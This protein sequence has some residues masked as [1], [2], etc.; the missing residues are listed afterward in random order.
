MPKAF[1][2]VMLLFVALFG[3]LWPMAAVPSFWLTAPIREA[4]L[5]IMADGLFR[6]GVLADMLIRLNANSP[7]GVVQPEFRFALA[8]VT[9]RT[10]EEAMH[11]KNSDEG[12]RAMEASEGELRSALQVIPTDSFLWLML[13]S[14]VTRR[15]GFDF[16]NIGYLE[17]SYALGPNEGWVVLRRNQ[18][19]LAVFSLLSKSRQDE[20]VAEF[21][22]LINSGF[23]E[24]AAI[25]LTG[26]G[27]VERERL[28]ENLK[29]L[30][31]ASREIFAKR[32]A[33]DGVR[34][35]I[36][37]IEQDERYWR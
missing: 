20:V 15:S 1:V 18:L 8:V 34:V 14:V 26:A 29:K 27:W 6:P 4:S 19:A 35:S 13:Y 32:L 28:L 33:R 31:V 2:R 21:A 36:P 25:S 12:D 17:R 23:I 22:A 9:L 16:E 5:R 24:E 7:R 11:R 30:D 10:A 37:G 3:T